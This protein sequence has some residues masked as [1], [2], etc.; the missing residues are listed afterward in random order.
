[1]SHFPDFQKGSYD[2]SNSER[3][4]TKHV[5]QITFF[6]SRPI[7]CPTRHVGTRLKQK[8]ESLIESCFKHVIKV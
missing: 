6:Y 7:L 8:L 4:P 3:K 1:M 5:C 2:I